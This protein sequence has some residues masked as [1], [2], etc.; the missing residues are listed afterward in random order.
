MVKVT[1]LAQKTSKRNQTAKAALA[2][3]YQK[4][5]QYF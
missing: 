2:P 1:I 3:E 5:K 4:S